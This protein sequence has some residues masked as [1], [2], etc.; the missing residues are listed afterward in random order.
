[1]WL[2]NI[3]VLNV[4]RSNVVLTT[5]FWSNLHQVRSIPKYWKA[6]YIKGLSTTL[7]L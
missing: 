6:T 2:S 5:R 1:M 3:S 4:P 7:D